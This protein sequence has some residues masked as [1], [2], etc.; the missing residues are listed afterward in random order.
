M[1]F[2]RFWKR[3][4]DDREAFWQAVNRSAETLELLSREWRVVTPSGK[5]K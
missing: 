2:S 1:S 3:L 5:V 4:A